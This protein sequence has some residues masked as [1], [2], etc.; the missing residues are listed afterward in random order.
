MLNRLAAAWPF[1]ISPLPTGR[2]PRCPRFVRVQGC[3]LSSPPLGAIG[4]GRLERL[5]LILVARDVVTLEDERRLVAADR[6]KAPQIVEHMGEDGGPV[7]VK[8][9]WGESD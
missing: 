4:L 3:H 2:P 5:L 6:H 1:K 9:I 8:V 7:S